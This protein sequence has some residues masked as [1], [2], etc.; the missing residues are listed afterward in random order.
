MVFHRI[1]EFLKNGDDFYQPLFFCPYLKHH[2]YRDA[3]HT[4]MKKSWLLIFAF[5]PLF[6][7]AQEKHKVH[8]YLDFHV[9]TTV[10]DRTRSNNAG[11]FGGGFETYLRTRS[12]FR[13]TLA[14]SGEA[15]G[16][17]KELYLTADGRPIYAKSSLL[18][19]LAGSSYEGNGRM[20]INLA[21]G[22][23]FFNSVVHLAVRPTIGV[24]FPANRQFVFKTSFTHIWQ[25]DEI[26]NDP[27]GFL[28]FAIGIRLF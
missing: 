20:F 26:S 5:L 4:A 19:I 16:G 12:K 9:N 21:A 18:S 14:V 6:C 13:P 23:S 22:P 2:F 10:Y 3:C 1:L 24:Y 17:T 11:G 27:F 15:F 8:T 25:R 7:I 28:S